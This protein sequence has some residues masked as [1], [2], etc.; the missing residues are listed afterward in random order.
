MHLELVNRVVY[1]FFKQHID[2]VL[3][4]RTVTQTSNIHA[5]TCTHMLHVGEV[6]D[7]VIGIFYCLL[8]QVLVVG[9]NLFC[10][11]LSVQYIS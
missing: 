7:I 1:H 5:W 9:D 2:T 11:I 10:H 4:K 8:L 3:W 6:T